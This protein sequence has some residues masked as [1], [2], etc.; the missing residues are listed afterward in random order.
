MGRSPQLQIA[1]E[2]AP[3]VEN[4]YTSGPVTWFMC[5]LSSLK[6]DIQPGPA[7]CGLPDF[8][9]MMS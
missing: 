9:L 6:Q 1:P 7:A 8:A 5:S 2:A 4:T 3:R